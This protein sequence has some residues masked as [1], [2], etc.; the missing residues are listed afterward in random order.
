MKKIVLASSS[1]R[2]QQILS[3]L[4]V[5]FEMSSPTKFEEVMNG[6]KPDELVC[7]NAVGKARE[8]AA[9]YN[10][11]IIIG[12]DTVIEFEGEI[13]G[14]PMNSEKAKST[15]LKLSSNTHS[16]YSG[17]AVIDTRSNKE[18]VGCEE[19][20][21]T[22][23]K[24]SDKDIDCY[25]AT[26]EPLDKAGAYGIQARGDLFVDKIEGSIS[27]VIGLPKRLLIKYLKELGVK[28]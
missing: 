8:I 19:T 11:A 2:R 28:M 16:V 14:K 4:G 15:L 13:L 3:D 1:P 27:N 17:L 24:I 25:I 12:C 23:K 18:M 6:L 26:G 7:R 10:D 22:F 20:R 5:N 9:Q 21:I